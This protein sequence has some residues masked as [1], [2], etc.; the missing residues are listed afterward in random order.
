LLATGIG[1]GEEQPHNG[2]WWVGSSENF[3]LGFASGYAMAMV[4]V[5]DAE[6]F[7]CLADRN[8]GTIPEK[9]PG[10]EALKACMQSPRVARYDFGQIRFGQLSEGVDEFYKDFR[11]K[12][13]EIDLAMTYVRDELKGKST[14]ELEDE[15]TLWRRQPPH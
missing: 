11:N 8:G 10:D 9:F 7:Q 14:K 13:L 6:G 12:G 2:F 4:H 3:K 1:R 15:L 5:S